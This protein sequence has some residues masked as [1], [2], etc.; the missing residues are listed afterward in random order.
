LHVPQ[1]IDLEV[2]IV[3]NNSKDNTKQIV[4]KMH[5][6]GYTRFRYIFERRQGLSFARN[7]GLD[8]AKGEIILFTDDDVIVDAN[9]LSEIV[10]A[11]LECDADCAGGKILPVWPG[12]RPL[13]LSA[14]NEYAL[15][16]LDYGEDILEL[17]NED[18]PLFGANIAF[19]RRILQIVGSFNTSLG[20]M[21]S[22]LY[23]SE[24]T[25][26]YSRILQSNAKII[27][28]PRAIVHHV[29]SVNRLQKKYF[30]KWHFEGGIGQGISLGRYD[31]RNILGIPFYIIREFLTYG[32]KYLLAL[33]TL[34]NDAI[35]FQEMKVLYYFGIMYS[36]VKLH[37]NGHFQ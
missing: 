10:N 31:K 36:R 29:I 9:W 7:A 6:D 34:K 16:L 26:I 8:A 18:P 21:G 30:R 15:A 28:Q 1:N 24:D 23:C 22:K 27:Y 2:L 11:F 25:E 4:E 14:R 19:S 17:K 35:F 20:R 3:D 5:D 13:W 37:L 12:D 32:L 33:P